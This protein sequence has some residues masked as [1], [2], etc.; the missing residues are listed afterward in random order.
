[1]SI[2]TY[3]NRVKDTTDPRDLKL[4]LPVTASTLPPVVDFRNKCSPIEDQGQ[5]GSCTGHAIAGALEYLENLQ[6]EQPTRIS[7]LFVYY[8]ERVLENDVNQDAGAQIR[9]G[10]KVVATYGA[11][12]ET[13]WPYVIPNFTLKPTDAAYQDALKRK[14]LAYVSVEQTEQALMAALAASNPIVFGISVYSSFESLDVA[15][16]GIVPIPNMTQEQ[17]LGGH[18]VLLVGYNAPNRQFL[19]RN[20]WGVTWGQGGYCWMPFDYVLNPQLADSFWAISK[21]E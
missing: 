17:N 10:I 7:R 4:T 9:D 12:D 15:R 11:C 13:L 16:T 5:L 14:A 1:M 3:Y 8:N 19:V 20:S 2:H 18:C 21:I 6:N